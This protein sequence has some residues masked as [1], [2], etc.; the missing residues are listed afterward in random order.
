MVPDQLVR[1]EVVA[2][3]LSTI[4]IYPLTIDAGGAAA[5][6]EMEGHAGEIGEFIRA[7]R[8]F[9]VLANM[10]RRFEVL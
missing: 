3:D 9:D 6:F 4:L 2:V 7:P 1:E 5:R 10:N 8:A